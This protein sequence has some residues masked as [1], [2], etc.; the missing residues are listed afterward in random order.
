M[1]VTGAWAGAL[2][3]LLLG[4]LAAGLLH[5]APEP[6]PWWAP[7]RPAVATVVV[8]S[9]ERVVVTGLAAVL[10]AL[11]G[12]GAGWGATWPAFVLVGVV[13]APLVVIDVRVHRLPDRIVLPTGL[14][15]ALLLGLAAL[16]RDDAGPW[17]RALVG[18][19]VVLVVL[20]VL[21]AVSRG[22]F[23]LG[24][25]KTAAVLALL[26]GW[27]SAAAVVLGL[28][29]GFLVAAV[30]ALVLVAARRVAWRSRIA[31]GPPLLVGALSVV[32]VLGPA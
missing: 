13:A 6:G 29:V 5:R 17:L 25:V 26:L 4:P 21:S 23:G 30:L 7:W 2:A 1:G 16:V 9:R 22:A 31:F 19:V 28:W 27:H 14:A 15:V 20:G 3:G 24:D 8:S 12:A 11:A 10:A 32:A 18:A